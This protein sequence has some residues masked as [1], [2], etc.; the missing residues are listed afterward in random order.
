MDEQMGPKDFLEIAKKLTKQKDHAGAYAQLVRASFSSPNDPDILVG[1]AFT[2]E[3]LGRF[4]ACEKQWSHIRRIAPRHYTGP[5]QLR[6]AASLVAVGAFDEARTILLSLDPR[7]QDNGEKWDLVEKIA[8]Q[9]T[10]EASQSMLKRNQ[11][12]SIP[13]ASQIV[14]A[15]DEMARSYRK[16]VANTG[17]SA[18]TLSFQSIVMVTYGRTGSTLLQGMLN[19][20]DG[21]IML[22]ENENAFFHL[23]RYIDT[24]KRLSIRSASG[25]PSSPFYGACQLDV[26]AATAQIKSTIT[27]YFAPFCVDPAVKL[28]GLKEVRFKDNPEEIVDYLGFLEDLLP[29]PAFVFLWR[30]HDEVLKSGWWKTEDRVAASA[31]LE[32]VESEGH[33]FAQD[34]KNCFTL[35]YADLKTDAPKLRELFHFLG[36]T[37]DADKLA[38]VLLIPHSYQPQSSDV[39]ALFE[40]AQMTH[41]V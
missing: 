26:A 7:V 5:H 34:R 28:V 3:R 23:Y 2:L 19:T 38:E 33:L 27:S 20:I 10:P 37:Y 9:D 36:A 13:M 29:Q 17:T 31:L 4:E 16:L 6:H 32:R 14:Q 25:T 39:R 18:D 15:N 1:L 40:T 35:S 12:E 21:A 30:D 41:D 8:A 22:G 11:V 24:I